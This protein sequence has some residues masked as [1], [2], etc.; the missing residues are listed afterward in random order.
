MLPVCPN[1]ITHFVD[2]AFFPYQ[3]QWHSAVGMGGRGEARPPKCPQLHIHPWR[4]WLCQGWFPV[5][6]SAPALGRREG[7]TGCSQGIQPASK[8]FRSAPF[9]RSCLTPLVFLGGSGR[10]SLG[11][12]LQ[13]VLPRA[14]QLLPCSQIQHQATAWQNENSIQAAKEPRVMCRM[15]QTFPHSAVAGPKRQAGTCAS[16]CPVATC[17]RALL[18]RMTATKC[19]QLPSLCPTQLWHMGK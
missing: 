13:Q 1:P 16:S 7:K 2:V 19:P 10:R 9:R 18:S 5:L 17:P 8:A 6:Q 3:H 11:T 15:T 4:M 12:L 14:L